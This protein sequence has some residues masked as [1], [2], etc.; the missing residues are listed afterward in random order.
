MFDPL[1][2]V[3]FGIQSSPGVYALLLGSGV[4]R[5]S[6]IKTGWE[7]L[8]DL[9][10][11]LAAASGETTNGNPTAWFKGNFGVDADYSVVL[12]H[13]APTSA[14]RQA[15]LR[16]YFEPS[17]DER[18]QGI[19]TPNAAHRAIAQLVAGKHVRII[20]TTNFDRLLED[21]LAEVG[22]RP[23]IV[24]SAAD[25]A[26]APPPAHASCLLVK[27]HG[28]YLDIG[29]R[30]TTSELA[31]YEPAMDH[32]L[33]RILDDY[34]LLVCGWSANW[35]TA[36]RAAIDRATNRRYTIYWTVRSNPSD[37][38]KALIDSRGAIVLT[39][40]DAETFFGQLTEKIASIE[41]V[42]AKPP[43]SAALAIAAAKRHLADDSGRIRLHDLFI[44]EGDR[45]KG[46]AMSVQARADQSSLAE[47]EQ[48]A[49]LLESSVSTLAP[50]VATVCYWGDDR[51]VEPVVEVL[52]RLVDDSPANGLT[53]LIAL[54]NYPAALVLTA[55]LLGAIAGKKWHTVSTLLR[56]PIRDRLGR[57]T[58]A[59]VALLPDDVL[60][61]SSAMALAK[62][63]RHNDSNFYVPASE[64]LHDSVR[65]LVQGILQ[66][67]RRYDEAFDEY[68]AIA[69]ISC[70]H[71][72]G[73]RGYP[74]WYPAGRLLW[75][76]RHFPERQVASRWAKQVATQGEQWKYVAAG[77]I[78]SAATA[79]ELLAGLQNA[80]SRRGVL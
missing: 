24:K 80:I 34:G 63:R 43:S 45:A 7:V 16:S 72:M 11:K 2:Q 71:E 62:L 33:D 29:L 13:L 15:F 66:D 37:A 61:S 36:L 23:Q 35:D 70:A 64:L 60:E 25:A 50:L 4:S 53:N 32:L 40:R 22:V 38:A 68:E 54:R 9:C 78:P 28:D 19:K 75:R 41:D 8:E 17:P 79:S 56:M 57:D 59:A 73:E 26:V 69:A 14:E 27:L 47:F 31:S 3:A 48:R 65:P 44:A 18:E 10:E 49:S 21:A 52:D 46:L 30:N 1:V 42:T 12:E 58:T 77:L 67:D 55:G 6:G 5:A 76:E 20:L 39:I 51:H 74:V